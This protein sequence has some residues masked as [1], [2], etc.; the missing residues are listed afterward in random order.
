MSRKRA[1]VIIPAYNMHDYI[2]AAV[3]S[4]QHQ[5]EPDIE[6]L[7]T[8]DCS[9]DDTGQIV[10]RLAAE[11]PRIRLFKTPKNGGPSVARNLALQ[12]AR[13]DWIVILDADDEF[14]PDRVRTLLTLGE[15]VGADLA[16]DSLM[17]V[18]KA[19]PGSEWAMLGADL[20][21]EPRQV[22][23]TEFMERSLGSRRVARGVSWVGLQPAYRREF[24]AAHGLQFDTANR[25]GEDYLLYLDCFLR[26]AVMWVTPEPMYYHTVRRGSLTDTP[27]PQ[28]LWRI[29]QIDRQLMSD[30]MIR[31]D[32]RL[33]RAIHRHMEAHERWFY[34]RVFADAAK[35]RKFRAASEVLFRNL[36]SLRHVTL[37]SMTQA[38]RVMAKVLTGDH[39]VGHSLRTG[40]RA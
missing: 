5:T 4:A 16:A 17:I 34:Y 32:L 14:H 23:F 36:A 18:D 38:P 39:G 37:E 12:H 30:P 1:S 33:R 6:I 19:S 35:A 15:R 20:V 25:W 2:A 11:D 22:T 10:S 24:L 3:Q 8:D 29:A 31:A 28:D 27:P 26:R 7:V 13:G 21:A 40:K 9:Q